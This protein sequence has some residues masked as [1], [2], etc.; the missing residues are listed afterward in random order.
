MNFIKQ[1]LKIFSYVFSGL[2]FAFASFYLLANLYHYF[3]LRKDYIVNFD[4]QY[5]VETLN[6]TLTKVESN[7]S[8]FNPNTYV[9]S[10]PT[11]D[12][13]KL[14]QNI[15]SCLTN[16]RN[17]TYT[18]MSGKNKITIVD[19]YK[20]RE[21]Y[22]NNVLNNCIINNLYWLTTIDDNYPSTILVNNKELNK[23]Y[24]ESLRSSTT[25][26][27]KDLNNNSSYFYNTSIASTAVKDNTRDGFFEV[28]ESYQQAAD[29]LLYLSDWFKMEV[30]V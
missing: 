11:S 15:N 24:F 4:T 28:I 22:E 26:L 29:Y 17:D 30:G 25:Y 9:G 19:V 1:Y 23:L 8:T 12:M 3:E 10:I 13:I 16:F 6:N 27:K 18:G 14:K 5:N 21:S 2:V 7:I 20:L